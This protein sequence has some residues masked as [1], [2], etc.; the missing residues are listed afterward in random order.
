MVAVPKTA[1]RYYTPEE[2][3]AID[4]RSEERLEYVDGEILTMTGD[5]YVAGAIV[6][7]AGE[8]PEHNEVAG[9]IYV[10]IKTQFRGRP[11]KVYI[12]NVKAEVSEKQYRYPDVMALCG[13]PK[14]RNTN[15]KTLINP[16]VIFEVLSPSTKNKDA[17]EKFDEYAQNDTLTDYVLVAQ[18]AMR[19]LHYHRLRTN[20]WEVTIYTKI[21]DTLHLESL[22][23]SLTL[24]NIYSE[25]AF[26]KPLRILGARSKNKPLRQK[27]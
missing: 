10:E 8:S 24:T 2:Y 16:M 4:E 18:D 12:E 22:A 17:G 14:F 1:R 15:P 3:F 26:P 11:C 13:E 6:A 27:P 19:V 20:H 7:M 25:I 21:D 23:I 9:N 5:L